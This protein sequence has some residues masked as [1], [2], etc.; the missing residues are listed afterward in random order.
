M[1]IYIAHNHCYEMYGT[2]STTVHGKQCME[3]NARNA[4]NGKHSMEYN[5]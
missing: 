4:R 3:N 2:K 5:A 1:H